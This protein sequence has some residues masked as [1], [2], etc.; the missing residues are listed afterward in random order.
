MRNKFKFYKV[1]IAI[2]LS[3]LNCLGDRH[4]S[5]LSVFNIPGFV[6]STG[7]DPTPATISG[8]VTG[9]A[10]TGLILSNNGTD[11][12]TIDANGNFSFPGKVGG[13]GSYNITIRQNPIS[14]PQ[15]C[16]VSNGSG[17]VSSQAISNIRVICSV[18]GFSIGGNVT[19]LSGSG[20]VLQNNGAD[21]ISIGSNGSFTFVTKVVDTGTYNVTVNQNPSSPS[22]TCSVTNASGLVAGANITNVN[23]SCSTNSYT[24]GG[25]ISGLSGSGLILKNNG[26]DDL[27]ITADGTYTFSTSI[28]S[29]AAYNVTVSQ[30]PSSPTQTCSV[31]NGSSLIA[32]SNIGNAN[33]TCSTNSYTVSGTVSGLSG[34]GLVLK[35]NGTDPISISADGSFTFPAS[36]A[37]GATY[38]VTVSQNPSSPTQV[39]SVTNDSGLIA[40]A[41]ITNVAVSCSTSSFTIGGSV[42]GLSGSGLVLKN[43]GS[44]PISISSNG[45]FS[46]PASIASGST[47]N[48]TVSQDPSSPTQTCSVTNNNGTVSSSNITNVAVSCS[49]S[50]F[51]IGGSV[52]N[53]IGNGLV[54]KNNGADPISISASGSFTFSTSI[55]SGSSYAVTIQQGPTSPAQICTLS[56]DT[57]TVSSSNISNVSVSCGPAMYFVGGT[58]AGLSGNL[59]L[60]NNGGDSTTISANGSFK[61]TTPVAD[62]S[63]FNVSITGQP[64]GQ[65]CYIAFPSGTI[66]TAD[67]TSVLINCVNGTSL[68][69]L[70]NGNSLVSSLPL[71]P[72]VENPATGS[73]DWF[74]GDPG[75]DPDV[76]AD[77]YGFAMSSTP[78]GSFANMYHITTDGL[79]LY[80]GDYTTASPTTGTVRKINIASRTVSS[81]PITIEK[82]R[83]IT[84]DGIFL[85]ITSQS[86]FIV[87]YNLITN[88]YSTIAGV[89]GSSGSTDGVGTA[90]RFNAPRGIATDG[91]YLYVADTGNHKIRRIRISDNTVTTIAGSGTAGTQDGLGTAAKFNQPA[92]VIYDSNAL[93][94]TDTNSNNIKKIDLTTSPVT[95][96]TIAGDP[97]GT[98]GNL[99][100]TTG[101][102][103]R[104]TKPV[105]ISLDANN[106]YVVDGT[107]LI[108]KISRTAPYAVSD[109]LG[110]SPIPPTSG[111]T[112]SGGPDGG[113]IG[114]CQANEGSFFA[115][116]GIVTNGR[117]LFV[118]EMHPYMRL[119]RKID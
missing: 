30:N 13:G 115:P 58:V 53:V 3:A 45:S 50:S 54:L 110:C 17:I 52:S 28:A 61:M 103:A 29:G 38:T 83:G 96:T 16:S 25:N 2:V 14:P 46:F 90:A 97:A 65:T 51:T 75:A 36:I 55:A 114:T 21:P 62:A 15:I 70:V 34:G 111:T 7:I 112:V 82:P 31:T 9:L 10:G 94:V 113:T 74:M 86:H 32:G 12:V 48:V 59:I 69:T 37:S 1:L 107:T 119:V 18:I 19:G 47:Y 84:T 88:A 8:D 11:S 78:T 87:K 100:H 68:G 109:L 33:I 42:S 76:I 39:C 92:H 49:T 40:G 43:N 108:K 27:P 56:N 20:L 101:T 72:Y 93:Y 116:R 35:N 118:V 63:S 26:T 102:S 60:Q 4:S 22:Q 91:T 24:V 99:V 117:S 95:V 73:G 41:N 104:L 44:D 66:A 106:F 89:N 85:Y 5:S 71:A 80:A 98:S 67:A 23:I 6:A 64:S 77:G 79:N 81:L 57:G 105:A